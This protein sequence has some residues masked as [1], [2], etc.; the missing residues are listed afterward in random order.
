[1]IAS[2]MRGEDTLAVPFRFEITVEDEQ[3]RERD[4]MFRSLARADAWSRFWAE[5]AIEIV[6][7]TTA[8]LIRSPRSL[9]LIARARVAGGDWF[10]QPE[11]LAIVH[12]VAL[13]QAPGTAFSLRNPLVPPFPDIGFAF[14]LV[15]REVARLGPQIFCVAVDG[16][17]GPDAMVLFECGFEQ[18]FFSVGSTKTN[19]QG[20]WNFKAAVASAVMGALLSP[21][22]GVYTQISD[23]VKTHERAVKIE[24]TYIDAA[25]GSR[26][27]VYGKI[28]FDVSTVLGVPDR[29][30]NPWAQHISGTERHRRT[31]NLQASL[32][33]LTRRPIAVDG[34]IGPRTT[35][36]LQGFKRDWK[37]LPS[38]ADDPTVV[39]KIA[40]AL[41][42]NEPPK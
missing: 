15:E 9:D 28:E 11:R 41:A 2:L 34:E 27:H 17:P 22:S 26:C 13:L 23:A 38:K 8:G 32:V 3:Q 1:M 5:L 40:Q 19:G 29:H 18:G 24:R 31:C 7:P 30:L 12:P 35:E 42:G 39:E 10:R 16:L 14:E 37:M 4:P 36:A 21:L 25:V 6:S 33:A 20:G